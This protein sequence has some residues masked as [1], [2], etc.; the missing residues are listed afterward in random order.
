MGTKLYV[1]NLSFRTT[2]DELR[3]LFAQAG[4]V[5]SASVI[6]DRET[7]RSRGFGFVEMAT[8]EGA[9]AAIEQFNGKDLGGRALTVNEARPR[10]DRGGGGG[11][12]GYGGGGGGRGGGGYGGGG[13]GGYGGGR[14]G[15]SGGGGGDREPRW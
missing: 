4:E 14:G 15:N 10:E 2:G 8:P 5:E 6:E 9:A 7:G 11:R 1:G 12:G 13:G 3:D